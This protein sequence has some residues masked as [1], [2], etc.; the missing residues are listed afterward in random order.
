MADC[1]TRIAYIAEIMLLIIQYC[2]LDTFLS[3]RLTSQ[4]LR[5]LIQK[6]ERSLVLPVARNTL[7]PGGQLPKLRPHH[8][9][10]DFDYLMDTFIP[11]QLA[12]IAIDRHRFCRPSVAWEYG[13]PANSPDGD[14]IRQRIAHGFRI[15]RQ[16]SNIAREVNATPARKL[17]KIRHVVVSRL[18]RGGS[19][20][21]KRRENMILKRRNLLYE[22]LGRMEIEDFLLMRELVR[23]A[24]ITVTRAPVD[25]LNQ[26]LG[27]G[28][29]TKCDLLP[30]GDRPAA[31]SDTM[32]SWADWYILSSGTSL[33]WDQWWGRNSIPNRSSLLQKLNAAGCKRSRDQL[34]IERWCAQGFLDNFKNMAPFIPGMLH[35]QLGRRLSESWIW[36]ADHWEPAPV[37]TLGCV[38]FQVDIPPPPHDAGCCRNGPRNGLVKMGEE[39][40]YPCGHR[41]LGVHGPTRPDE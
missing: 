5:S 3:L 9:E 27:P 14:Q 8:E 4:A 2:D 35:Y 6:Y 13:F 11:H 7:P 40:G 28:H 15:L 34:D 17:P 16:L 26:L 41:P 37:D 23:G 31:S 29:L 33:F 12:T 36:V 32:A 24:F 20:E 30:L 1:A 10:Y 39:F 19:E 25:E 38:A 21:V 22:N 18:L